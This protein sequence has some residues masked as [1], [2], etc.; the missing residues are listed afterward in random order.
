VIQVT[1]RCIILFIPL[2]DDL[3]VSI[4]QPPSKIASFRSPPYYATGGSAQSKPVTLSMTDL[5]LH[6]DHSIIHYILPGPEDMNTYDFASPFPH[7]FSWIGKL[8]W[9]WMKNLA[10]NTRDMLRYTKTISMDNKAF[11]YSTYQNAISNVTSDADI[12]F[13]Q[14][15]MFVLLNNM[16]HLS[17]LRL[18]DIH[19][20]LRKLPQSIIRRV[21]K[22][23]PPGHSDVLREQV[24]VAAMNA[25]DAPTIKLI[26]NTGF[27][28]GYPIDFEASGDKPELPFCRA[29]RM[30]RNSVAKV[31]VEQLTCTESVDHVL[32]QIT[33][34]VLFR[35]ETMHGKSPEF[36]FSELVHYLID[37]GAKPTIQCLQ[38]KI[39][40]DIELVR[41]ILENARGGVQGWIQAGVLQDC[42]HWEVA[43]YDFLPSTKLVFSYILQEKVKE[44]QSNDPATPCAI[45][46]AFR[47][48]LGCRFIWAI[49]MI[50]GATSHLDIRLGSCEHEDITNASIRSAYRNFDWQLLTELTI[51]GDCE[52]DFKMSLYTALTK[53]GMGELEEQNRE[54]ISQ[55]SSSH[56][57][58]EWLISDDSVQGTS[59]ENG[60]DFYESLIP[61]W[62]EL[63]DRLNDYGLSSDNI[64]KLDILELLTSGCS[65]DFDNILVALALKFDRSDKLLPA[66][67]F[68]L[69]G[70]AKISAI[71]QIIFQHPH[72]NDALL[73]ARHQHVF[74]ALEDR[75]YRGH[76]LHDK[77]FFPGQLSISSDLDR[78]VIL[79]AL[80]C[81]AIE[82]DNTLL[83]EWLLYTGIFTCE[84]FGYYDRN[85]GRTRDLHERAANTNPWSMEI[86]DSYLFRLP[87]LLAIA[88]LQN[89]ARMTQFLLN[90]GVKNKDTYALMWAVARDASST[91]IKMLLAAAGDGYT[92]HISKYGGAAL[93][94][95]IFKKNYEMLYLLL[96]KVDANSIESLVITDL[97]G[98][99]VQ[100]DP[101]S[102]MGDAIL[103][104]DLKAAGILIK[105]G[106]NV[107]GLVTSGHYTWSM[108]M[109]QKGT[110]MERATTLLAAIDT[111]NLP[112][113]K[114]LVDNGAD[115]NHSFRPGLVRT[116]LQHAAEIGN[117][118]IVQYLLECGALSDSAPCYSGGTPL[119]LTAIGGYVGIAELLLEHG[120]DVNHLPAKGNGRTAFEGAAEWSRVDM[121]SLLVSRGLNFDLVVDEEGHTQYERAM[122]FAEKRG[123]QASKR[124]VQRL[125]VESGVDVINLQAVMGG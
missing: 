113:V 53:E 9:K 86:D 91:V 63:L 20:W 73:L 83:L 60:T 40:D 44:I 84:L 4:S 119:Q 105:N 108:L 36:S 62:G 100:S 87:S 112:M 43:H 121:M 82:T 110:V 51:N 5:S 24:F 29:L 1:R 69:F 72:W 115:V 26:L 95:A 68:N 102:P 78:E 39:G 123:K 27:D 70:R 14:H 107:C 25:G 97:D 89:N 99:I 52:L 116:P 12:N 8:D 106:A 90:K 32:A 104:R 19:K 48:A 59:T 7:S 67:L 28:L 38:A 15:P 54:D 109:N 66:G 92:H 71:S 61:G 23:L 21:L 35:D 45:R 65:P 122:N 42:L 118:E 77:A 6:S 80:S 33:S 31:I 76:V 11:M 120:A 85:D 79:R 10:D 47:V 16:D 124:F 101:L 56:N 75:L 57:D 96:E 64:N 17:M 34:S 49:D 30:R 111:E 94:A 37:A 55:A 74:D 50:L 18:G 3:V 125:R 2:T 98:D 13:A 22:A 58:D 117:F 103:H 114:L 93:R 81:H 88:A 46:E 41:H